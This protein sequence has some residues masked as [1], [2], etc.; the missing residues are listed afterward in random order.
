MSALK[1]ENLRKAY[2]GNVAVNDVSFTID[3]GEVFG[4]LGPNGAGKSTTINVIATLLRADAGSVIVDGIDSNNADTYKRRLGYVPQEI[5]LAER[6]TARE[7]LNLVGRLYDIP[8]SDLQQRIDE[9]LE[10]VGLKDRARDLVK[11]FSGGMKR[12]LNI[13]AALLHDPILLLMD[14]PTAGVDPHARAYIFELVERLAAGGKAI[15]YTTHYMEEAQRLCRRTAIID[16][17][18]I[19][20][21]GTLSDLIQ[22]INAKRDLI[23]EG[24]GLSEASVTK[25]ASAMGG[26]SWLLQGDAAHLNVEGNRQ[27]ILN[28]ARLAGDCGIEPTSIRL[29]EANLE[30]VFLELTGRALRD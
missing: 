13:A 17:G 7:N 11:T 28:A 20:A 15:L 30:T 26:V 29:Q 18:R 3:A 22:R 2:N 9:I 1:V 6:L 8:P 21:M 4:L 19:L 23:L 25:L 14:E 12:R 10:R 27:A 16:H 24:A 5:S